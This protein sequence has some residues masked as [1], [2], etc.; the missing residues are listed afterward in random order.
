MH[1]YSSL[2]Q[3]VKMLIQE[4]NYNYEKSMTAAD[5]MIGN[6]KFDGNSNKS[7]NLFKN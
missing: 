4:K 2:N 1:I 5:T 6:S 3:Q 7:I